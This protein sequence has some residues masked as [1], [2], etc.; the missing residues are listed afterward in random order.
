MGTARLGRGG[1][2]D[3]GPVSGP[4]ESTVGTAPGREGAIVEGNKGD[5][6]RPSE[7]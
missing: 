3:A 5:T 7:E 4:T 2:R 1:Q 6:V